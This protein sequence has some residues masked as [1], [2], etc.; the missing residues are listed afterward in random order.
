MILFI[1]IC[2]CITSANIVFHNKRKIRTFSVNATKKLQVV[3]ACFIVLAHLS[4]M[5]HVPYLRLCTSCGGVAVALFFFISGYG[6]ISGLLYK[7]NYLGN[8]LNK[9][10]GK[11]LIPFVI[12]SILY[13]C[14]LFI[15]GK[16]IKGVDISVLH[17]DFF[18]LPYS[19]Y[20]EQIIV[21]YM[22]FYITNRF[23]QN[24]IIGI[25]IIS[26]IVFAYTLTKF[27]NDGKPFEYESTNC[28]SLGMCISFYEKK[29]ETVIKSISARTIFST[30]TICLPL[31]FILPTIID[32]FILC[33]ITYILIR[34]VSVTYL[35]KYI[36]LTI[37][38]LKLDKISYEIYLCQGVSFLML[39][40]RFLYIHSNIIFIFMSLVLIYVISGGG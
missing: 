11:I 25:G 15:N 7:E 10:A 18:I 24:K 23:V 4:Q 8:F 28:F 32:R 9:R 13:L 30:V 19:W 2:A 17:W 29:I 21:L 16:N 22:I 6:L 35:C 3:L 38:K 5:L 33:L 36:N 34:T 12:A 40:N 31:L 39:R 1:L 14:I 37:E 26:L 20:V 27:Y